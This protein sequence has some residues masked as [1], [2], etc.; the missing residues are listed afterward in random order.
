[1]SHQKCHSSLSMRRRGAVL[2][3][4]ALTLPVFLMFLAALM[5][6]GHFYL[7]QHVVDGAA[8]RGVH[9][10]SLE[11][12]TNP[13]VESKIKSILSSAFTASKATVLIKNAGVFD[14]AS[15]N[16]TTLN[17]GAL[18]SMNLSTAKTGDY[19]LV[20]IE[21]PYDNVALLPP[22]WLQNQTIRG[23]ALMRHE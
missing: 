7:I 22:I 20:Q 5:E 15:V 2:V 23:R 1:M 18:P 10:G 8:R 14:T 12:S 9:Y 19:F 17:Y 11:N 21:V 13:V 6:F 16:P 4:T 3:E